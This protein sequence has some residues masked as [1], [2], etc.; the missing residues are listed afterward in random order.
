MELSIHDVEELSM[1]GSY[2]YS[3]PA[4]WKCGFGKEKKIK[5][6]INGYDNCITLYCKH[7]A[8]VNISGDIGHRR[9]EETRTHQL[10]LWPEE[11]A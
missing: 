6:K 1:E 11:E 4:S 10:N 9:I 3:S 7:D 5:I 2:A 8:K